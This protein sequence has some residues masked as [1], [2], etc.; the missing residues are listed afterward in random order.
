[1][2]PASKIKTDNSLVERTDISQKRKSHDWGKRER[3]SISLVIRDK[4]T[5]IT[6]R[7]FDTPP[8]PTG[9]VRKMWVKE[10]SYISDL[11]VSCYN[12]LDKQFPLH[13]WISMFFMAWQLHRLITTQKISLCRYPRIHAEDVHR[14][15]V[16]NSKTLEILQCLLREKWTKKSQYSHTTEHYAARESTRPLW[17]I[18]ITWYWVKKKNKKG[19]STR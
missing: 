9:N 7:A 14:S 19:S 16:H 2:Y 6:V 15:P 18:L 12:H 17:S 3:C 5:E 4:Q 8:Y 13:S 11:S 10:S 1:M